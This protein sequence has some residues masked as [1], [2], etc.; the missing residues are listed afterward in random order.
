[1][2]LKCEKHPD[3]THFLKVSIVYSHCD[4]HGLTAK[5]PKN[6]KRATR[7]EYYVCL[8]PAED[9]DTPYCGETVLVTPERLYR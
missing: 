5:H 1:M 7:Q 6:E 3:N 8:A 4:E 9:G 2:Y